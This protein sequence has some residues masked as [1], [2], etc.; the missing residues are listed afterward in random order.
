MKKA[1]LVLLMVAMC[2]VAFADD[3]VNVQVRFKKL[4]FECQDGTEEIVD[5]SATG[6]NTY[7]HTCKDGKW[8]NKFTNYSGLIS[9]T[10]EE[11][12]KKTEKELETLKSESVDKWIYDRDHQPEYVEPTV[13]EYEKMMEEKLKDVDDITI[14]LIEKE[15]TKLSDY[16]T[17]LEGK[18]TVI[19]TA[20]TEKEAQE[21]KEVEE[22][23]EIKVK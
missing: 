21:I 9:L 13:E 4:I 12:D 5:A 17:E 14:K 8:T 20:I 6:G 11:Y 22:V 18:T 23:L 19:D 2:G 1:F 16:I 15:S 3:V 10:P 7:E